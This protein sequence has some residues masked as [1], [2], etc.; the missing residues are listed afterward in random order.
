MLRNLFSTIAHK[1]RVK[2]AWPASTEIL[3]QYL[4]KENLVWYKLQI[5]KM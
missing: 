4:E 1:N 3:K 2:K 5:F